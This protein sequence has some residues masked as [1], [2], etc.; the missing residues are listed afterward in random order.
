MTSAR[1][2]KTVDDLLSYAQAIEEEAVSR[3]QE[4]A[5]IM[6]AH[7]NLEVASFFRTMV[8]IESAHV[9]QVRKLRGTS[10]SAPRW[11][12]LGGGEAPDWSEMHYKHT[13]HHA[14]SLALKFE[15]RAADFFA[16][17][18]KSAPS[19]ELRQAAEEMRKEE[20]QHVDELQALLR[21]HASP[22]AD[23]DYDPDPPSDLE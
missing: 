8:T 3:Y 17:V 4:L 7:N 6:E 12:D 11:E 1:P 9:E 20:E 5:D 14:I 10:G 23:W 18:A 21:R 15:R 13:P 16:T 19:A 22:G 2:L